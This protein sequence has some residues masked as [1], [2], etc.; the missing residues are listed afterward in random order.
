[1]TFDEEWAQLTAAHQSPGSTSMRLNG[2]GG[3]GGHPSTGGGPGGGKTLNVT[4]SVLRG[5]AGKAETV[6]GQFLK[7]DDEVMTETGQVTGS[8]KGFA[9]AK[10]IT[11][12][13]ERWRDQMSY[14]KEEFT[15]TAK[16]LRSGADAFTAEDKK[17]AQSLGGSRSSSGGKSGGNP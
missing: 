5:R 1:M 9:T 12:F 3:G 7:A 2:G 13:Q 8:L 17:R 15:G 6:R 14:V 4:E 10:A 16:A 11:T